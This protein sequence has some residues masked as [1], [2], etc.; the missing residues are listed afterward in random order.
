MQF[1]RKQIINAAE[2]TVKAF[3]EN[4]DFSSAKAF[5]STKIKL[6]SNFCFPKTN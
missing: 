4:V 6:S 2:L 1:K 5:L 3:F